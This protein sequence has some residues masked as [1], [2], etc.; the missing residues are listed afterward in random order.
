METITFMREIP[1]KNRRMSL[2]PAEGRPVL[3]LP[4]RQ[5]EWGHRSFWQKKDSA[6]AG[7]QHS[8]AFLPLCVFP[9][10]NIFWR[11]A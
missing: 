8:L 6:S 10:G 5:Q 3:Q 2:S 11:E 4:L 1:I 7:L 9:M